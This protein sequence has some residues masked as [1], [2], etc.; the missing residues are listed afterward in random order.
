[1]N[2]IVLYYIGCDV[3]ISKFTVFSQIIVSNY[4]ESKST[5]KKVKL[6]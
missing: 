6:Y 5:D 3:C 1:V 2:V 4:H